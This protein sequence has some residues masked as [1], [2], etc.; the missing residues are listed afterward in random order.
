MIIGVSGKKQS[1]KDTSCKYMQEV[2]SSKFGKDS[3]KIYSFADLL[4][5]HICID[6]LGLSYEQCYGTDEQKNSF[7]EYIW[8]NFPKA[9]RLKNKIKNEY[10]PNGEITDIIL[11]SG[12]MTGREIM[13]IVGTDVF[14]EYFSDMVWVNATIRQIKKDNYKFALICDVRFPSEVESV[15]KNDGHIVRLMRNVC[16]ADAHASE[17]SLDNYDWYKK[18]VHLISNINLSIEEQNDRIYNSFLKFVL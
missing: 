12:Y 11:P 18:N 7:T 13:Q 9:I 5:K 15:L 14:R 8:E 10:A 3:C 16:K 2:F 17:T 4:K 1:G 6:I